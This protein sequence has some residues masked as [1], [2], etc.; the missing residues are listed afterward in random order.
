MKKLALLSILLIL[1]SAQTKWN[2]DAGHSSVGFAIDHMVIA[3]V[4]GKFDT[5]YGT[6]E[7]S[8]DDF[9]NAKITFEIDAASVNTWNKK[10]DGHLKKKDFFN[11]DEFPK[12]SFTSTSFKKVKGKIDFSELTFEEHSQDWTEALH[13]IEAGEMPPEDEIQPSQEEKE[14][15]MVWIASQIDSKRDEIKRAAFTHLRRLNKFEYNR[16]VSD[17]LKIDTSPLKVN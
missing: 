5:F 12:I 3:E 6:L 11:T 4:T 7:S 9:E 8:S 17:L 16:T 2:F 15:M 14:K 10:R 1:V 13:Q